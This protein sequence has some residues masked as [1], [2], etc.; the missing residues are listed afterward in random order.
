MRPPK[1]WD[2]PPNRPGFFAHALWPASLLVGAAAAWRRRRAT[3]LRTS[4]P[5]VCVGNLVVGGAGKTPTVR[6]ICERLSMRGL[7]PH[8]LSRGYRG[9]IKG[10]HRVDPAR[11]E[12]LDVGDEPLMLAQDAP[13]WIGADR[14]LTAEAAIAAGA[15]ALVMDDGF[16]NPHLEKDLSILVVDA[17]V[18]HGNG[19]V[20]PAGPLREP[21]AAGFARADCTVVIGRPPRGRA[22]PTIPKGVPKLQ[23]KLTPTLPEGT[24]AGRP[25][26]AFAGIGRPAKFFA[27]LE[28]MGARV[29]ERVAFDDHHA[30]S[31]AI[32]A[33]L[34]RRAA[35]LGASLATTEKDAMRLPPRFRHRVIV[36]PVRLGFANFALLDALLDQMIERVESRRHRLLRARR[37]RD[38]EA[39]GGSIDRRGAAAHG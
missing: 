17:A 12:A 14:R 39:P 5:V 28:E 30:F 3:P 9:R 15:D 10:P 34:D 11:D 7:T 37:S 32:L 36:V 33:R 35:Q 26:L 16:Q 4:V 22:H 31:P 21:L 6:A 1:F 29:V 38:P 20:I 2:R 27:T 13:V 8:I 19:R 18:G 23:A 25:V 24:L